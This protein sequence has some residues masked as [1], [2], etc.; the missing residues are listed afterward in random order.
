MPD[1]YEAI[2]AG[3]SGPADDLHAVTPDDGADLPGGVCRSIFVGVGGNVVL[4]DKHGH[5]VTLVSADSQ[6]HPIRPAR[7]LAT[8]TTATGILALY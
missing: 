7:V 8:G 1:P 2:A 5:E 6:Y 3:L 4:R